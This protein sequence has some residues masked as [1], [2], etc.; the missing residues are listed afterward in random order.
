M[1]QC[2]ADSLVPTERICLFSF[3]NWKN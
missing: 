1:H 2:S 3:C